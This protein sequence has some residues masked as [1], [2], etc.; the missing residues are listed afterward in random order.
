VAVRRRKRAG[1]AVTSPA[2]R[3]TLATATT[4]ASSSSSPS[5]SPQR[6][7]SRSPPEL[8]MT[9]RAIWRPRQNMRWRGSRMR[10]RLRRRMRFQGEE[11]Q[12]E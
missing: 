5:C 7:P 2:C 1:V 11:K 10:M 3:N 12:D 8:M 9:M 6:P 4:E